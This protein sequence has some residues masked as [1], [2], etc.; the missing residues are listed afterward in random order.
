MK[1]YNLILSGEKDMMRNGVLI[2][3]STDIKRRITQIDYISNRIIT[4]KIL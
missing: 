3:V 4:I 1:G 2:I